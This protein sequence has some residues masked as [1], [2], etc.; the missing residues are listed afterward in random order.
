MRLTSLG[1]F[2]NFTM[3]PPQSRPRENLNGRLM[4]ETLST[5]AKS[6]IFVA[7]SKATNGNPH[8]LA[9]FEAL[10]F[11]DEP[12]DS[13][14]VSRAALDEF[15]QGKPVAVSFAECR[16]AFGADPKRALTSLGFEPKKGNSDIWVNAAACDPI[17]VPR[18]LVKNFLNDWT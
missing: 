9:I 15:I 4:F 3:P 17:K 14:A 5:T 2:P 11:S 1:A 12:V 7:A 10:F 13:F 16:R 6:E 8:Q 18:F